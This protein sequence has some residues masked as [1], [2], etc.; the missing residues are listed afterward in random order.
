MK[1]GIIGCGNWAKKIINEI[2]L[3]KKFN[4]ISL[5]CRDKSF[6]KKNLEVY[7]TIKEMIESNINDCIY[8]AAEPSV[9]LEVVNLIKTKKIPII[10]EKPIS[11]SYKNIKLLKSITKKHK[12][13][14]YPNL[15]NY[16]AETFGKIKIL[17]N[18]NSSKIKRII[19]Y[20]GNFGPFRSNIHPIWDWGF[21]PISLLYLLFENHKFSNVKMNEIKLNNV[22]GKG[23]VSKFSF[24]INSNIKVD[25]V[26][27]NLFKKKIRKMKVI[28]N[29]NDFILNDMILHKLFFNKKLKFENNLTPITS[30][31]NSFEKNL[32]MGK[33]EESRRLLN[34]SCKTIN[35]IE[36]FYKY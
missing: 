35:F 2:N 21:H 17:I 5:V 28:L 27:G 33:L 15:T 32:Q 22:Y 13:F 23:I 8:V 6:N 34:A 24:Y 26:T 14:V 31:L 20:E 10:L 16:F 7:K 4:L 36:N 3:H 9:N 11:N 12:L 1:I 19:I 25:V 18:K 30:L 29:N